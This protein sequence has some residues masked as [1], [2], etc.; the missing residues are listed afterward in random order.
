MLLQP[1]RDC[2]HI[3]KELHIDSVYGIGM[4]FLFDEVSVL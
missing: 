1:D 3:G 2:S 4:N